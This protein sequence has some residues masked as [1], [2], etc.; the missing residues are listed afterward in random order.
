[1][2]GV[3]DKFMALVDEFL[4]AYPLVGGGTGLA[5]E[6]LRFAT[7]K[8]LLHKRLLLRNASIEHSGWPGKGAAKLAAILL[9]L[10][11]QE[12]LARN[13]VSVLGIPSDSFYEIIVFIVQRSP[14]VMRNDLMSALD[15]VD[16]ERCTV[17]LARSL[18]FDRLW[19]TADARSASSLESVEEAPQEEALGW[20]HSSLESMLL[21]DSLVPECAQGLEDDLIELHE[22]AAPAAPIFRQ[23]LS[24]RSLRFRM[25]CAAGPVIWFLAL[26]FIAVTRVYGK[27]AAQVVLHTSILVVGCSV[28]AASF[29]SNLAS[30]Q[31]FTLL[32]T[33]MTTLSV[34]AASFLDFARRSEAHVNSACQLV[35][36]ALCLATVCAWASAAISSYRR[37]YSWSHVRGV[38][39]A[40]G[41][42][43]LLATAAFR[44][45]GPPPSYPPGNVPFE[46]AV[47]RGI[48]PLMWSAML[49]SG[50]R[51]RIAQFANNHLGW[52]HVTIYL[53]EVKEETF[54]G[55]GEPRKVR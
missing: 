49:T 37:Q 46:I 24:A 39:C 42:A 26:E 13:Q 23:K 17:E 36:L 21:E 31:R 34:V 55:G 33:I 44:W 35:H 51:Q 14:G 40:E 48:A 22:L 19:S 32:P 25:V 41:V 52:N 6:S 5:P 45:F 12:V 4:V 20:S 50:L 7:A 53:G 15:E 30:Q 11:V 18:E 43:F 16:Q 27:A 29:P 1:M 47:L 9:V 8:L 2:A 10:F 3:G 38:L 54:N 28:A